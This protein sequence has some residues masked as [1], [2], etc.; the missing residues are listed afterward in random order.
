V[1]LRRGCR[2]DASVNADAVNND[3]YNNDGS[4]GN[5]GDGG[6]NL[7]LVLTQPHPHPRNREGDRDASPPSW[8]LALNIKTFDGLAHSMKTR[9]SSHV[10]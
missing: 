6:C 9:G 3:N 4:D 2:G 1:D 8:R 7:A 10:V 5:N